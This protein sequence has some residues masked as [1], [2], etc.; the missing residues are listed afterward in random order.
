MICR[1]KQEGLYQTR[2]T[3]TSSPPVTVKWPIAN[4]TTFPGLMFCPVL[5]INRNKSPIVSKLVERFPGHCS[6]V[7]RSFTSRPS[8]CRC[9]ILACEVQACAEGKVSRYFSP[10]LLP[11]FFAFL[12][13]CFFSLARHLVGFILVGRISF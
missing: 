11:P 12:T 7:C 9:K 10:S 2:S 4:P 6:A 1:R 5:F 3:L 8:D 13:S